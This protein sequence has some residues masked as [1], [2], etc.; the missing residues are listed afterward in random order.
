VKPT[1][2]LFG[3]QHIGWH[4]KEAHFDVMAQ[5]VVKTIQ[6]ALGEDFTPE[7]AGAWIAVYNI[8]S[9]IMLTHFEGQNPDDMILIEQ[10]GEDGLETGRTFKSFK[11]TREGVVTVKAKKDEDLS[12]IDI[13]DDETQSQDY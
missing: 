7:V 5:A 10:E 11:S 13:P 12:Q 3:E 8:V 9:T 2:A 4:V 1:L 6:D